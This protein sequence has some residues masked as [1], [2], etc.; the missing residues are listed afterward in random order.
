MK[1]HLLFFLSFLS[2]F[3]TAQEF[4]YLQESHVFI[5]SQD[6]SSFTEELAFSGFMPANTRE[7]ISIYFTELEIIKGLDVEIMTANGKEK[8]LKKKDII[9]SSVNTSNFYGGIQK[10]SFELPAET[11]PYQVSYTYTSHHTDLM[12]LSSLIFYYQSQESTITYELR[13]PNSFILSYNISA[14]LEEKK[15]VKYTSELRNDYT[16]HHFNSASDSRD[17]IEEDFPYMGRIQTIV[18]PK[19]EE[20]FAYYNQWY[21]DLVEPHS[22]LN[23]TTKAA[24]EEELADL[25]TRREKI[26]AL[27]SLVQRRINYIDF[28][29]GIGAIQPRDVNDIFAKKQGDCKDMSN[30]L[31]QSL[32]HVGIEANMAI[33]ST[34]GHFTDLDFPS[35]SS[36]NHCICVVPDGEDYFF[37][38]ATESNGIFGFPSRQIQGRNV[39]VINDLSGELVRV[40]VAK[41][42]DNKVIFQIRLAQKGIDLEGSSTIELNGMSQLSLKNYVQST[43]KDITT[44]NI[45][46]YYS[47]QS[48]NLKYSDLELSIEDDKTSISSKLKSSRI[49]TDIGKKYYLSLNFLPFPHEHTQ[50]DTEKEKTFYS[51]QKRQ[52]EIIVDLEQTLRMQAFEQVKESREGM[53]FQFDI[54]QL[55]PRQLLV[56][57]EYKNENLEIKEEKLEAYN[58]INK[59]IRNSFSKTIVLVKELRP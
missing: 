28:E 24:I 43:T 51:T 8:H 5:V 37:L 53:Q 46:T 38:D 52:F 6:G 15:L 17:T 31:T 22:L 35:L 32:K 48:N 29:N 18:H 50:G 57:Y 14:E 25:T 12:F 41:M 54:Q 2:S 23:E 33:S 1:L 55:S 42:E 21:Q 30:L 16:H 40:P 13:V 36:A 20:A 39:F 3:S 56:K 27:F 7:V 10:Y 9:L 45:E 49:F 59:A 47:S 4:T 58:A 11:S 44:Q 34:L 19:N 26:A